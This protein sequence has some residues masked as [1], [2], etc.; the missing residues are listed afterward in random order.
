M[1]ERPA[2]RLPNRLIVTDDSRLQYCAVCCFDCSTC[3]TLF[4]FSS[5]FEGQSGSIF[6]GKCC[7]DVLF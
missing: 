6:I 2:C 4:D 7:I 3:E 5:V 1:E